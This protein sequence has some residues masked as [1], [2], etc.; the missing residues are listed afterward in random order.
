M[1]LIHDRVVSGKAVVDLTHSELEQEIGYKVPTLDEILEHFPRIIWN[2]EIKITE[3]LE[4]VIEV[5]EKH[6]TNC[7]ILVTSLRHDV[8]VVYA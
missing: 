7:R 1:G 8:V 6:Q 4:L 5:L 3:T 2:V